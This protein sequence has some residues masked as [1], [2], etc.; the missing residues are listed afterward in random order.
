M[1]GVKTFFFSE[2]EHV[3]Y[4][5]KGNEAYNIQQKIPL[6]TPLSPVVGSKQ[7]FSKGGHAAYQVK[8]YEAKNITKLHTRDTLTS[9]VRL[10]GQMS[11]LCR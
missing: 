5:I 7:L 4:Q 3:A 11:K 2:C 1:G 10:K 6:Y 9:G 8:G